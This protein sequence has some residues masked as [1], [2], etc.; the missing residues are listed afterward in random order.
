MTCL[1]M[2]GCVQPE[3]A[4]QRGALQLL[5]SL[6]RREGAGPANATPMPVGFL[7]DFAQ[8]F[9]QE[10][11]EMVVEPIG[12]LTGSFTMTCSLVPHVNY[13]STPDIKES[14]NHVQSASDKRTCTGYKSTACGVRTHDVITCLQVEA[15]PV[16]LQ[17]K[18]CRGGWWA[19]HHWGTMELRSRCCKVSQPS[20]LLRERIKSCAGG[21]LF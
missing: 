19:F 9:E 16:V 12:A 14:A 3:V 15:L 17:R 21:G 5:D 4:Q 6:D 20:S 13:T 2:L 8:R 18:R 1:C 11:L 7:E 10:G